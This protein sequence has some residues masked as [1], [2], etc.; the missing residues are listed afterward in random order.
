[1]TLN[2]SRDELRGDYER[3][4]LIDDRNVFGTE[5][6][7]LSASFRRRSKRDEPKFSIVRKLMKQSKNDEASALLQDCFPR[8]QYDVLDPRYFGV[9]WTAGELAQRRNNTAEAMQHYVEALQQFPT[10]LRKSH[11]ARL[12]ALG[13]QKASEILA[14]GGSLAE[15]D[16]AA[17]LH[18][19]LTSLEK[20]SP[21]RS[22]AFLAARNARDLYKSLEH[23]D[24][25]AYRSPRQR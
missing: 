3:L 12:E 17:I 14:A 4:L 7:D 19:L 18:Q 16:A 1:M 22:I 24:S 11:L 25:R 20:C 6:L 2:R 5:G 10:E 23:G 9:Y 13:V 21:S 8:N 15:T